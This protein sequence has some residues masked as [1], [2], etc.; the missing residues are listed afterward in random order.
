[1]RTGSIGRAAKELRLAPPT[2]SAQIRRLEATLGHK[3]FVRRGRNLVPTELGQLAA[4]YGDQI[5]GLGQ[6]LVDVFRGRAPG[7]QRMVVGVSD[8]LARSI[9]HRIL[10]PAFKPELGLRIICRESRSEEAFDAELA[11]H[12]MDVVLSNAPA[13]RGGSVRMYSHELG[14]C[15]TAWFAEPA[16]ARRVRRKFPRSFEGAPLLLPTVD[17]TFRRELDRWFSE[18]QLRP[19][20]IAEADDSSLV[21]VLGEQGLGI[22][23]APD[24]IADEIRDRYRVALVGHSREI[25]Q[26]FYAIS[27]EREIRHPGVAAICASARTALFD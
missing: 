19:N 25:V 9:V 23:A 4:R 5:F 6:E 7:P 11:G 16:L 3:L 13:S 18:Q 8:V 1:M 17:S 14:E 27:A 26:H 2:V 12:R 24:V 22:F 10:A 15:G 20:V 21:C